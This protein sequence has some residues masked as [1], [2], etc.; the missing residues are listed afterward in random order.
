MGE[1]DFLKRRTDRIDIGLLVD[2]FN[3]KG[4]ERGGSLCAGVC[5]LRPAFAPRERLHSF[6]RFVLCDVANV[7]AK[8][9]DATGLTYR[10]L[11][12]RGSFHFSLRQRLREWELLQAPGSAIYRVMRIGPAA[13]TASVGQ[14]RLWER[15]SYARLLLR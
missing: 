5:T 2:C 6:R 1:A 12:F 3:S 11:S 10:H 15:W 4:R 9:P 8:R 14:V 7:R 13:Q